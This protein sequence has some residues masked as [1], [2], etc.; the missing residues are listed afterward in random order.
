MC[1][2][3]LVDSE[4]HRHINLNA[5]CISTPPKLTFFMQSEDENISSVNA[6]A[7]FTQYESRAESYLELGRSD[8]SF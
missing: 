1:P 2:T 4:S 5:K 8:Q 6:S 7:Y 3:L